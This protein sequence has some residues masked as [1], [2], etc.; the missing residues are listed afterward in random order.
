M[1]FLVA[2]YLLIHEF[3]AKECCNEVHCH[4]VPCGEITAVDNGWKWQQMRFFPSMLRD[5]PDGKC[6]VCAGTVPYCLYLPPS[7]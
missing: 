1:I 4:P 7:T 5:S 3:Y 6:H 2:T